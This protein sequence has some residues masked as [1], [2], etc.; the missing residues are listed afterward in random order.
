MI[1]G[2]FRFEQEQ[3]RAQCMRAQR[4]SVQGNSMN[5]LVIHPHRH[6]RRKPVTTAI[7]SILALATPLPALAVT[8][9]VVTNCSDSAPG[10]LRATIAAATTQSGHSVD[11]SALSCPNGKLSLTS[12]TISIAQ[13]SLIILGPGKEALQIDASALTADG[14]AFAHSGTG[15]LEIRDLRI[16]GGQI[17]RSSAAQVALGGCLYSKGSVTLYSVMI[18][19]CNASSLLDRAAGGAVYTKGALTIDQSQ[20]SGNLAYSGAVSPNG[21]LGGGIA[22]IGTL[23]IIKSTISGNGVDAPGGFAL[24]GGVWANAAATM[25]TV[26][27]T[28][29]FVT[30]DHGACN[31]GGISTNGNLQF[32]YGLIAANSV[33][34]ATMAGGCG[35][36]GASVGG[37]LAAK[38]ST[39]DSNHA[40]GMPTQTSAG[41]LLVRGDVKLEGTTISNNTASGFSGGLATSDNGAFDRTLFLR[42]STVS[43]NHANWIGGIS[44]YHK[45]VQ[46]YNSTIAFNTADSNVINGNPLSPGLQISPFFQDISVK[47]QSTILSNNTFG[48]DEEDDFGIFPS[49]FAVPVTMTNALVRASSVPTLPT[50]PACPRLGP[51]RDNGGLNQTHAL[52]SGSP[53]ID[54]GDNVLINPNTLSPYGFDQRASAL[55]NGEFDYVRVSGS[56]ADVGA[57]EVQKNDIVFNAGFDG[58]PAL[59]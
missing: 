27:V 17:Y 18:D 7:A 53:A 59:P 33:T 43:G 52:L 48:A 8:N 10:S 13:N 54:H 38:Y 3:Q 46:I 25:K 21:A 49:A 6:V 36:G 51:L 50:T 16:S 4:L 23:S 58:C 12:S 55:A 35:A 56:S 24:G 41:G 40:F 39:I 30:S 11:L 34:L 9:W 20:I 1:W 57:Y 44:N 2:F 29:N 31:G 5:R 19:D 22:A 14:R 37:N 45:T 47:L 26:D 28:D 15:T 32:D 42:N